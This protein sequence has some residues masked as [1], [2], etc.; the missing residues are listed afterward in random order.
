MI[1]TMRRAFYVF[2]GVIVG[3]FLYF[4]CQEMFSGYPKYYTNILGPLAMALIAI[5]G[6]VAWI[7]DERRIEDGDD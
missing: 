7:I 3:L 1:R 6:G 2:A 5:T 4:V